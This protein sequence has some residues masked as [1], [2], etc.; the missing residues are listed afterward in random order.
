MRS[1][2]GD[3]DA[4]GRSREDF[5]HC[6]QR[7]RKSESVGIDANKEERVVWPMRGLVVKALLDV[8][9]MRFPEHYACF[10]VQPVHEIILV[11]AG[12]GHAFETYVKPVA[13]AAIQ[14][15][16]LEVA[17]GMP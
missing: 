7:Q 3:A 9:R 15:S 16:R 4:A 17:K 13:V 11:M 2:T 8:V 12:E 5:L 1:N 10:F 6:G 14:T